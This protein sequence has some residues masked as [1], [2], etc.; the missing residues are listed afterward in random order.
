MD[1]TV[2]V[3]LRICITLYI[4]KYAA[5]AATDTLSSVHVI[6]GGWACVKRAKLRSSHN[7]EMRP[8]GRIRMAYFGRGRTDGLAHTNAVVWIYDWISVGNLLT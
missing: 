4:S 2:R 3:R 8:A 7:S 6:P 1:N 5:I